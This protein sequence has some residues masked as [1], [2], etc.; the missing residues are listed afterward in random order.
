[1]MT[2]SE[3]E[4]FLGI[5]GTKDCAL[6]MARVTPEKRALYVDMA[7]IEMEVKLWLAGLGPKPAGVMIDLARGS[8]RRRFAR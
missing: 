6:I 8:R 1:M 5:K 7:K 4:T 3:L 2:D